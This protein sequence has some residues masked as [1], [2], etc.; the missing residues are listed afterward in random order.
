MLVVTGDPRVPP[1]PESKEGSNPCLLLCNRSVPPPVLPPAGRG[2][3]RGGRTRIGASETLAL[4]GIRDCPNT[5]NAYAF[6]VPRSIGSAFNGRC[7]VRLS[8]LL[9]PHLLFGYNGGGTK[10][11]G[12]NRRKEVS[13]VSYVSYEQYPTRWSYYGVALRLGDDAPRGPGA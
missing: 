7:V 5:V 4:P 2:I 3:G 12:E 9:F 6:I 1:L 13:Y 8:L 10:T 11:T